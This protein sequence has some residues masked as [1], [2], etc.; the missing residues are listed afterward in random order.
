MVSRLCLS[1][2]T[3]ITSF[4]PLWRS[5]PSSKGCFALISEHVCHVVLAPG[6]AQITLPPTECVPRPHVSV[7][8]QLSRFRKCIIVRLMCPG[9]LC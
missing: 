4:F 7:Q 5:H 8:A 9:V 2:F 3:A 6:L 1:M